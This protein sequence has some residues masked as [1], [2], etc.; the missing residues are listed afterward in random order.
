MDNYVYNC[1][2]ICENQPHMHTMTKQFFQPIDSNKLV[3]H[4]C[5][6]TIS[7]QVCFYWD[8]CLRHARCTPVLR[9]P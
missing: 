3:K 6:T 4:Y 1:D 9:W 8:Y 7:K 5:T 2:R